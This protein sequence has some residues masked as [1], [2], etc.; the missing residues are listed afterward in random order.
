MRYTHYYFII[1]FELK[2]DF[3]TANGDNNRQK[4]LEIALQF[5]VAIRVFSECKSSINT[6]I[7][8]TLLRSYKKKKKKF[9]VVN[10]KKL[11]GV[12]TITRIKTYELS[13]RQTARVLA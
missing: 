13:I 11:V 7:E 1:L 6:S 3:L 12:H 4:C 8:K 5:G 9:F 10:S 2:Q